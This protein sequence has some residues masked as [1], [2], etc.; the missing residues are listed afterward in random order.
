MKACMIYPRRRLR[1]ANSQPRRLR[2]RSGCFS[3]NCDHA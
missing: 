2:S 3:M 1:D